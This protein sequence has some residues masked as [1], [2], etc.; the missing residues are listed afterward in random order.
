M[1][2]GFFFFS[3]KNAKIESQPEE[4]NASAAKF[5]NLT[6]TVYIRKE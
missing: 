6:Y 4:I 1:K 5:T 2:V 3:L